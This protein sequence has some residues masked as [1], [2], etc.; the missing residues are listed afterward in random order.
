MQLQDA[1]GAFRQPAH[2]QRVPTRSV[3]TIVLYYPKGAECN[4][5]TPKAL[6]VN[7][8]KSKTKI[9]AKN[10]SLQD[11]LGAVLERTWVIWGAVLG[12]KYRLK[13]CVLN[14]FV[15]IHVFQKIAFQEPS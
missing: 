9:D 12:A 1:Q 5:K 2:P 8:P 15:K 11:R 7:R 13:P 14:G 4:F 10:T 3:S 6:S